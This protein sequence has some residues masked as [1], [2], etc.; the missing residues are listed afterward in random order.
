M[1]G[2]W[3]TTAGLL[4]WLRTYDAFCAFIHKKYGT[5]GSLVECCSSISV[6]CFSEGRAKLN[7]ALFSS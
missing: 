3:A 5:N 2:G 6:E 1:R 7:A 4:D